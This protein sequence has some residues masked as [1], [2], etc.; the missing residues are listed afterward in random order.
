M[1]CSAGRGWARC[2]A[3]GALIG[4]VAITTALA[5]GAARAKSLSGMEI[6]GHRGGNDFGPESTP[7]TFAHAVA[8]GAQAIEFDVRFTREGVPV[9]LHDTTLD[10]TTDCKGPVAER[11]L[12]SLAQCDAGRG[13]RIPTLAQALEVISTSHIR[14]YVHCKV[15]DNL[16]QAHAIVG[17]IDAHGLN[18]GRAATTIAD[19]DQRLS[20]L[21]AAGSQRLGLVFDNPDGWNAHYPVLIAYNTKVTAELVK[22]AQAQGSEVITVQDHLTSLDELMADNAGL[23]GFMADRLDDTLE[24]VGRYTV[25]PGTNPQQP[26]GAVLLEDTRPGDGFPVTGLDG[27]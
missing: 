8:V 12:A 9:V 22:R 24:Q 3:F 6:I 23:D 1:R 25:P 10:R 16:E 5:P 13:Q 17:E 27:A 19:T 7:A 26:D 15:V 4:M 11:S 18:D 20:F 21:R 2:A 14:V